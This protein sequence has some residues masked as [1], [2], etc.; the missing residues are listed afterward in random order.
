MPGFVYDTGALLAAERQ[1]RRFWL[2]HSRALA[3]DHT[4]LVPTP[5]LTEAWRGS[6]AIARLLSGCQVEV[7]D[8][9]R[10]RAAGLLLRNRNAGA[11]DAVVVETALRYGRAVVTSD[12][13]D[14]EA[15]A[16]GARR[17]LDIVDV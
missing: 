10:A 15:L 4:P 5:V 3:R 14:L 12:R 9:S 6:P 8:A 13:G 7:L 1:D 2:L 16:A 11:T 17:R